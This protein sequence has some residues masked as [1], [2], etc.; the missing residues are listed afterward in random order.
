LWFSDEIVAKYPDLAIKWL[1]AK[2]VVISAATKRLGPPPEPIRMVLEG[3][4]KPKF[5]K[6]EWDRLLQL[7]SWDE[8]I[9]MI[10]TA[11]RR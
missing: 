8:V 3:L 2:E 5:E 11:G 1:S 10:K 7:N 9:A 6:V 4:S